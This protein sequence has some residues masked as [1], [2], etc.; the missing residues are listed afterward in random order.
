MKEIL[1]GPDTSCINPGKKDHIT[2]GK[3]NSKKFYQELRY[4][5]WSM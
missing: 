2:L 4:L 3:S 1:D 5:P